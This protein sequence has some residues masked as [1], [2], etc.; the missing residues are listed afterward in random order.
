MHYE[1]HMLW[2]RDG[3]F[4]RTGGDE[5]L[6]SLMLQLFET[7]L[8]PLLD[9]LDNALRNADCEQFCRTAHSIKGAAANIGA[10]AMSVLASDI[11][12]A[13]VEGR[14]AEVDYLVPELGSQFFLFMQVASQWL[15]CRR[16]SAME[17]GSAEGPATGQDELRPRQR[18]GR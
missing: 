3:F 15:A 1:N 13:A 17:S 14:V 4:S 2:D 5:V 9:D 11:E 10:E 16:A 8:P 6:V 12:S 7:S 18:Q